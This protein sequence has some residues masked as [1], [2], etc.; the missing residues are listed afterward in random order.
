M[1]WLTSTWLQL[2]KRFSLT[3]TRLSMPS[4]ILIWSSNSSDVNI[5]FLP[6]YIYWQLSQP[7]SRLQTIGLSLSFLEAGGS[8]SRSTWILLEADLFFIQRGCS[9]RLLMS[10]VDFSICVA[11]RQR[12]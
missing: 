8:S 4:L 1:S 6:L 2:I 12:R 10:V 7:S 9:P 3:L 5:F 11:P